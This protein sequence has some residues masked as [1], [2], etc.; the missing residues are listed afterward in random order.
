MFQGAWGT[1]RA[2]IPHFTENASPPSADGWRL[3][4]AASL[5]G[6]E[7][8]AA[9]GAKGAPSVGV[10]AGKSDGSLHIL[11]YVELDLPPVYGLCERFDPAGSK[12]E[13]PPA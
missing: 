7:G 10:A 12:G 5:V 11:G 2:H 6:R 13:L 1:T 9:V 8:C 3:L 4:L